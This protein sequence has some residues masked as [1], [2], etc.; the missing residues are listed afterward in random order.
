M[1]QSI[2]PTAAVAAQLRAEAALGHRL[3]VLERDN[4]RLRRYTTMML[5]VVALVLGLGA[6]LVFYS[7]KAGLPGSPQTVTARQFVLRDGS[8]T[9]RGA[10]GTTEDG[11]VR[12]SLNDEKGRQRV[13]LSLLEDGS[14]GLSFADTADR[15]LAVLGLLPDHTTSLVLTDPGGI[16]RVVLGVQPNGS[17]NIVFADQS[18]STRAGLGVDPRG[19]GTFT[20]ADR[21][22]GS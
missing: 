11:S 7:G 2:D 8:G 4:R 12:I 15:K 14:A 10:W 1:T 18:G 20:L 19:L 16:P 3:D 9:V 17:S 13:R 21:S 6:A 5:V 22:A